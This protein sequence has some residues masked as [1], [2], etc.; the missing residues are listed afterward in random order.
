[1]FII[2]HNSFN[3]WFLN[4]VPLS[5]K[6]SPAPYFK[7]TWSYM[8]LPTV[9]AVLSFNGTSTIYFEN[10]SIAVMIHTYPSVEA[11]NGPARSIPHLSRGL[12]MVMGINLPCLGGF[13]PLLYSQH[14]SHLPQNISTS[15]RQRNQ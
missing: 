2:R 9:T 1:M 14:I 11:L 4:S 5:V 6:I 15:R 7:K 13:L 10:T 8:A 3:N 12:P